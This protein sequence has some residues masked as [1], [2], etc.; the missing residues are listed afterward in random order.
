MIKAICHTNL[1]SCKFETFP[2]VF[3]AVPRVG[4][5]VEGCNGRKLQVVQVTHCA[6]RTDSNGFDW[7]PYIEIELHLPPHMTVADDMQ[8]HRGF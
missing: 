6:K 8:M 2:G 3:V 1:D 7:E 5:Y 4:D